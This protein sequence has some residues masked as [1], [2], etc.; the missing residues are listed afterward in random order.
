MIEG[1]RAFGVAYVYANLLGNEAGRV[2]LRRR[3]ADRVGWRACWRRGRRFCVRRLSSSRR[4]VIDID[5]NAHASRR[6]AAAIARVTMP[7]DSVGRAPFVWPAA[8]AG[9]AARDR[10]AAWE[11]RHQPARRRSSRAPS[12]WRCSDYLRKSRARASSCQP[13]RRR[14]LRR[15]RQPGGADGPARAAEELGVEGLRHKLGY[16]RELTGKDA[17]AIARSAADHGL[18]GQRQQLGGDPRGRRPGRRRRWA[19][20]HLSSTST[21][22]VAGY[23]AMIEKAIGRPLTWDE[24]RRRAAEHPGARARAGVWMLANLRGALL[25]ATS[26]RSRG[27]GRLRDDGRRHLRRARADRRHRQGVLAALAAVAGDRRPGGSGPDAGARRGRPGSADAELRPPDSKQIVEGDLM[28]LRRARRGRAPGDTRQAGAARGVDRSRRGASRNTRVQSWSSGSAFL[29]IC[30]G[31]TN[32]SASAIA[33]SL[34][35]RRREPGP[36]DVVPVP[37]PLGWIST[38]SWPRSQ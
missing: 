15:V 22:M 13:V 10:A 31:A 5:G 34:P 30:S 18:P 19:R 37:D 35:P 25:L 29:P 9:R 4:A 1:S 14:R 20:V 2:D 27:G 24:R 16:I 8:H 12:R 6:A 33:P 36:E 7:S 38:A 3:R 32:G 17:Q 28:P 11:D 26:N 21:P 23:I